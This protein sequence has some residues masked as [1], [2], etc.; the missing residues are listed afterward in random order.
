MGNLNCIHCVGHKPV[1]GALNGEAKHDRASVMRKQLLCFSSRRR[2]NNE[3]EEDEKRNYFSSIKIF[4]RREGSGIRGGK[5]FKDEQ[6][7]GYNSCP[8]CASKVTPTSDQTDGNISNK[9]KS[10]LQPP[11]K[12][13]STPSE[14]LLDM[15]V[16]IIKV[17]YQNDE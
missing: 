14:A 13:L 1:N 6:S 16:I 10:L 5:D 4:N 8:A 15:E 11:F 12:P 3:E 7:D 17:R 2:K 9:N